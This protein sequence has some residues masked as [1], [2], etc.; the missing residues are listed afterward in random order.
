[1]NFKQIVQTT[2]MLLGWLYFHGIATAQFG[3]LDPAP[4]PRSFDTCEDC[5]R[6]NWFKKLKYQENT[7]SIAPSNG[8]K[9]SCQMELNLNLGGLDQPLSFPDCRPSAQGQLKLDFIALTFD[10]PVSSFDGISIRDGSGNILGFQSPISNPNQVIIATQGQWYDQLYLDFPHGS[11]K[12]TLCPK[13]LG[14]GGGGL[15]VVL[16]IPDKSIHIFTGFSG[17]VTFNSQEEPSTSPGG[18]PNPYV[19]INFPVVKSLR[20]EV[21]AEYG[22]PGLRFDVPTGIRPEDQERL[23]NELGDIRGNRYSLTTGPAYTIY[24]S[25][26]SIDVFARFGLGV[27]DFREQVLAVTPFI[28]NPIPVTEFG[29]PMSSFSYAIGGRFRYSI[30]KNLD[31]FGELNLNGALGTA[32]TVR[33]KQAGIAYDGVNDQYD[34]DLLQN[35]PFQAIAVRERNLAIAIGIAWRLK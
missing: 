9:G 13:L 7:A 29:K 18:R 16:T 32:L 28:G 25:E 24:R 5:D 2:C 22:R 8:T 10:T 33:Q 3:S 17:S 1:M 15:C 34:A 19:G 31:A 4:N 6:Q 26:W 14:A 21:A 35:L 27:Y 20:W 23:E 30:G 12:D 11:G